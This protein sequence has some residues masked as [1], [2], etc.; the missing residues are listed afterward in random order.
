MECT[1]A[2]EPSMTGNEPLLMTRISA[3]ETVLLMV[4]PV[5]W[6]LCLL[7]WVFISR[8]GRIS[9]TGSVRQFIVKRYVGFL[10]TLKPSHAELLRSFEHPK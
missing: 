6:S 3:F 5:L 7:S 1:V 4:V 10:L 8:P 2:L 9:S